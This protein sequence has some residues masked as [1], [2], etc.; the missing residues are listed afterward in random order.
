MTPRTT[1]SAE[2]EP[3]PG[4]AALGLDPAL[5]AALAALGYEEP[6]PDSARGDPAAARRP[7]RARPGR[8]RHGQDRRVRAP[9]AAAHRRPTPTPRARTRALILVP[10]R[11]LAM[12][13]AEAV[14]R[15]GKVARHP[16]AA[17]STAARRWS[18]S[19][20]RSSAASTSS[21]RRP[22]ARSTTSAAR[23]CGST[24]CR[25]SCS[26]RPTRC[27]T[28]ASPRISRRSSTRRPR[29][30]RP[31]SS[32]RRCRRASP[33]IA[34]THLQESGARRASP[35]RRCAP[36][37]APRVRA[38]RLHRR[39]ARTR[40]PRSVACS[41]WRARRRRSSSAAR[42]PRSTSSPRR[43]TARGYR[44]EALHGGLS[45]EQRDRVMRR[46]RDGTRPICSSRPTSRRAASTSSTCRTS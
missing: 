13:V 32:P 10:T 31:R 35:A 19:C 44:A 17:R 4:F 45:Q 23:R 41:T 26:T 24:P 7:R 11:E 27:S 8:D 34:N 6:T 25:W 39:S 18:S 3:T 40:S 33:T 14:H 46:F 22:A 21:S 5:V 20:A 28:W 38:D 29:S 37:E 2:P 9:D 1:R 16:R 30:G 15:Y 36:G 12:Q 42:A 43:S